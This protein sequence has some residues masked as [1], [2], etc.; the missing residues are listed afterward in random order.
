MDPA[1]QQSTIYTTAYSTLYSDSASTN[2]RSLRQRSDS[3][4]KDEETVSELPLEAKPPETKSRARMVEEQYLASL[5][6]GN[7]LLPSGQ[8]L[9]WS[10]RGQHVVFQPNDNVPLE[11]IS[12]LGG[13]ATGIVEKVLCRRIALARKTIRVHRRMREGMQETVREVVHLQRLRHF[14]LAQLVGTYLRG[15]TFAILMYPVADSDLETFLKETIY[16]ECSLGSEGHELQE[17]RKAFLVS[18]LGCISSAVAH[19]HANKTNHLDIKPAN[20][21]IRRV[22][23][24][25]RVWRVYL[26]DFGIALSWMTPNSSFTPSAWHRTPRYSAPEARLD[27]YSSGSDIFSL[28]CVFLELLDVCAG[29]TSET[30]RVAFSDKGSSYA[31]EL[32]QITDWIDNS[33]HEGLQGNH[34]E[35]VDPLLNTLKSMLHPNRRERPTSL[36]LCQ[37]FASL[38]ESSSFRA[39]GCCKQPPEPYEAYKA[40]EEEN[41]SST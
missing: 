25:K 14:H 30:S 24:D 23:H 35:I 20:I 9:D 21:L 11:R 10:G 29:F 2:E 36:A 1:R 12:Y 32:P 16:P 38:P 18:T 8:T 3:P 7:L 13:G 27:H 28:G 4:A 26:T 15:N 39:S 22:T 40:Y 33:L 5:S 34:R 19:V 37:F 6:D 31:E 41:N 17:Q